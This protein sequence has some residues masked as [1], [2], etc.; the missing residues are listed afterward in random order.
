[1][2]IFNCI[3]GIFAIFGAVYCIFFPGI[4]FL[5]TGWIVTVLLG[6]WGVCAIFDYFS[7]RKKQEKS[8]TG[9]VL[10]VLGL[11]CGIGAAVM[12]TLA[13]FMPS[14]RLVIDVTMLYLFC[15]WMAASG[16]SSIMSAIK[17]KGNS[18]S[19]MWVWT[20]IWGILIL[21]GAL[22][23][24]F[25]ML[26]F[27]KMIGVLIGALLMAYGIRLISSVFESEI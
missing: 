23:G 5:N 24:C 27:A 14:L 13:L 21:I 12:S 20:L 18:Q 25:H 3:L 9:V 15:G 8:K 6:A 17:Q 4:S 26:L 11:I 10:G 22:Y 19:K 2:K 16:V 7:N 1:M